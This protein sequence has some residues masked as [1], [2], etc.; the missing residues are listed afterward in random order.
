MKLWVCFGV[1]NI[2]ESLGKFLDE[3]ETLWKELFPSSYGIEEEKFLPPNLLNRNN[4]VPLAIDDGST[5][6]RTLAI[7]K[8]RGVRTIHHPENR[9]TAQALLSA[10]RF[11]EENQEEVLMGDHMAWLNADGEH[12]PRYLVPLYKKV[13]E[14]EAD[15]ALGQLSYQG[16]HLSKLDELFN[17]FMGAIQGEVIFSEGKWLLHNAPGCWVMR[18]DILPLI[19]PLYEEYLRFAE[20]EMGSSVRWGEVLMLLM[21]LKHFGLEID[22]DSAFLSRKSAPSRPTQKILDQ[23]STNILNLELLAQFFRKMVSDKFDLRC[24]TGPVGGTK[25]A[26]VRTIREA[27]ER[28]RSWRD[29][30][31]AR[32]GV[33]REVRYKGKLLYIVGLCGR[34]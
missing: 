20:A 8:E 13:S 24:I 5:D 11:L 9:G 26:S 1:W 10:M 17:R 15:L 18:A 16:C 33:G 28:F 7:L 4:V 30:A 27:R 31:G 32:F 19:R 23:A 14:G 3:L 29:E 25:E 22:S 21:V 12:D 2:G 34:G 6:E